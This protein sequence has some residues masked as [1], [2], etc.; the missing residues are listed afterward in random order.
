MKSS[1]CLDQGDRS[2]GVLHTDYDLTKVWFQCWYGNC[3]SS[4][5]M[6]IAIT[7]R[8][9]ALEYEDAAAL[10]FPKG[11]PGFDERRHFVLVEQ[12]GLAPLVFLQSLETPE[13]CFLA[14]PVQVVDANYDASVAPDDLETL[15][16]DPSDQP[17][18]LTLLAAAENGRLTA[19]LLAPVVINPRTRIAVQAVRSDMRYSH[20]HALAGC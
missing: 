2:I 5:W 10:Q 11:L 3:S 6:H 19:N 13:L 14:L 15:A 9:G 4:T 12:A 1:R 16:I 20:Q 7:E 18:C 17:L 8:F